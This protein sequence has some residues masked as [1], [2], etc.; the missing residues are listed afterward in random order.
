MQ[1]AVKTYLTE[2]GLGSRLRDWPVYDS[3]N[4]AA[5]EALARR[6]RPVR[7]TSGELWIEVE[8]APHLQELQNFT[9]ESL[10]ARANQLL[11]EQRT[12][13]SRDG[14]PIRKLVFK[15]KH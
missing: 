14:G 13:P 5:G 12:T 4:K 7:F 1:D 15:L 6:A 2:S 10:R 11:L 9:G 8:S 3:W